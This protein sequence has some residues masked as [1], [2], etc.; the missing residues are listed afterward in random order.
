MGML[1]CL[2]SWTSHH[3]LANQ[4]TVQ[5]LI[6]LTLCSPNAFESQQQGPAWAPHG[7]SPTLLHTSCPYP[8]SP[9]RSFIKSV[10][11]EIPR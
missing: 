3:S 11:P 8:S 4:I 6:S 1:A 5:A 10:V 2:C 9:Q 7:C